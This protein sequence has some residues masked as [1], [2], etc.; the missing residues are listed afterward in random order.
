[1]DMSKL[2]S[3]WNEKGKANAQLDATASKDDPLC[4]SLHRG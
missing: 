4:R 2:Y 1:M 3:T